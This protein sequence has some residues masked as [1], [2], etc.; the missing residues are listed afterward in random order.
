MSVCLSG[1]AS[2]RSGV[3][4]KRLKEEG[5]QLQKSKVTNEKEKQGGAKHLSLERSV[6]PIEDEMQVGG[7]RGY[8]GMADGS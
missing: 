2:Q 8:R 7:R 6:Y 1:Y 4:Q 5:V 3:L